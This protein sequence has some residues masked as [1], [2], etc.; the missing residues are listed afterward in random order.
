MLI[1]PFASLSSNVLFISTEAKPSAPIDQSACW[2]TGDATRCE[3][4][5]FT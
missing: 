5:A 3:K 1:I 2:A 4:S